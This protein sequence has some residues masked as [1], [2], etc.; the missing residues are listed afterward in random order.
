LSE[1]ARYGKNGCASVAIDPDFAE[2]QAEKIDR[3]EQPHGKGSTVE[4]TA[5]Q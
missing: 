2:D 1:K 4:P 5:P 3:K